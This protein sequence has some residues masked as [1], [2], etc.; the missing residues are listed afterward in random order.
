MTE[1][2]R[3]SRS[4]SQLKNYSRCPEAFRLERIVR[5][6][7]PARPASWFVGGTAFQSAADDWEKS[8]RTSDFPG[9]FTRYYLAGIDELKERQPDLKMWLKPPRST[10]EKDIENRMKAG[11]EKW[12]PNYLRYAETGD[13]EI[14]TT[15]LGDLALEVEFTHEFPNGVVI[16][17]GID[18]MLWWP[19]EEMVTIED[20]KT[21]N[22]EKDFRQLGLYGF[23]ANYIFGDDLSR[24]IDDLRYFYAKDGEVSPWEGM[25]RW[26]EDYLSTE[27]GALD[28]GISNGVFIANPGDHCDMCGVQPWCRLKGYLQEG[29]ALR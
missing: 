7:L 26:T 13:W 5:P 1:K 16:N 11:L 9:D 2:R 15:P 29:E 22:R 3:Y 20:I 24:P 6:R 28:T 12:I 10:V 19:K 18:R 23:V 17:G 25:S 14:W 21:G 27:Y 8:G 4:V